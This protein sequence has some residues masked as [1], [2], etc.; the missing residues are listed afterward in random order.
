MISRD[1]VRNLTTRGWGKSL[2]FKIA[3]GAVVLFALL[4]GVQIANASEMPEIQVTPPTPDPVI[5]SF[6][7]STEDTKK[8]SFTIYNKASD[9]N[10][11]LTG[12]IEG[13]DGKGIRIEPEPAS[14]FF[15][16]PGGGN[17]YAKI[18]LKITVYEK[19]PIKNEGD[20]SCTITINSN[21]EPEEVEVELTVTIKYYAKI[22]APSLIDF[23]EVPSKKKGVS[24]KITISEEYGYKTLS[25][26]RIKRESGNDWVTASPNKDI[27]VS[28]EIR[29]EI[30]F[31]L[32]PKY[33][34]YE[35]A[36][37]RYTW[38]FTIESDSKN[39]EPVTI[40][41]EARI[42][43]PPKLGRLDDEELEIKFD[44]PKGTVS[45]YDRYIDVPVRNLGDE[46]MHFSSSVSESPGGGITIRIDH[47]SPK[48][49]SKR[50][51]EN[52]KVHIIAP[53]DT[54]E[55]TYQGKLFIDT[56]E[57]KDGYVKI[58][59]KIIWPVDF[60]ISSFSPYFTPSPPSIDF[61]SLELKELGYAKKRVNLT[62]TEVYRYKPVRN[63]R[64]S[65][66]GEYGNWL[67]EEREFLE[68]PPGES[69]NITLKIEP[70][71]EAV[72]KDYS[73]KYYI[74]AYEIS[75]K[76]IDVKARIVPINIPEMIE[77]LNS[78]RESPLHDGY[79][80]SE[81]IIS[82]GVWMLE[83]VEGSEIGAEDWK[84]IPVLMKG[85]L[86]LLSS[87]NDGIMS[88]E[89]ENYGKA[90]ENLVSASVSTSTIG[91]NSELNN[92]DI[93]GYAKDISTGAD[94]TTEEVLTDEA[95][96][97]ELRGWNIKKAVEHA[98]ALDDISGLKE[99]ENVLE[100]ALSY[101]YAATIYGL[102]K[103][104]EK[105]IECNYEE[106]R[107]MDKHDELVSDATDLRI[108]AEKN[109][110]NAEE[111]DLIR[112]SDV[113]LLLNPYNYDTFSES[114]GSAEKYLEDALKNYKVAGESLM[115]EDTEKK[116]N[117]VKR[118]RSYILSLFFLACILY[119]AAFIYT[120]NRV[121]MGT[122]AYMRDMYERE[123]GD[124]IVK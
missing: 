96:M 68:I 100:S 67:K 53:Y 92:W 112:I 58:T 24:E 59:I 90:V 51:S 15:S 123:V 21:A 81:V 11:T 36:D 95:K 79:P 93:S 78:F 65:T 64:F 40:T 102:L 30:T 56:V 34:D 80:S 25:D 70:G 63:L 48:E 110:M 121:I 61:E 35:R 104:K 91:S 37:N 3:I 12:Y 45:K 46:P 4:I 113:Y 122:M 2:L 14:S 62:L 38:R 73:W 55:G 101:Q 8:T 77:Y 44:K 103:D 98:M 6:P 5:F 49:V 84:K 99:E 16:I 28:R 71:L 74:S 109:I 19:D 82:N 60:T 33:F 57:D 120:I 50:G 117:E 94:K 10:A 124:I 52:I 7:P 119:G 75:A 87:L 22:E 29:H 107:L 41:V 47:Y 42:M 43:R 83:V 105:R 20:H 18:D 76:R 97:L 108:K 88:S 115:A 118:K 85:T 13:Y 116:L 32:E 106:S 89:E 72:P 23:G 17:H 26:V 54:P 27:T 86:S 9:P 69:G 114:Y 31:T 39:V 1:G 66:S 111:N